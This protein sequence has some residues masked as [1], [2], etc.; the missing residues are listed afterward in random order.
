MCLLARKPVC[1]HRHWR[2]LRRN[3]SQV[4]ALE[5]S[6]WRLQRRQVAFQLGR[7]LPGRI[8]LIMFKNLKNVQFTTKAVSNMQDQVNKTNFILWFWNVSKTA[9]IPIGFSDLFKGHLSHLHFL[10]MTFSYLTWNDFVRIH[11]SQGYWASTP[12]KTVGS[13]ANYRTYS[14]TSRSRL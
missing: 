9:R 7:F 12:L 3:W 11:P 6:T 5:M 14:A 4:K 1:G 8:R 13:K 2:R 10:L